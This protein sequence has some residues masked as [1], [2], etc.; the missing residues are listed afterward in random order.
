MPTLRYPIIPLPAPLVYGS[1][2]LAKDRSPRDLGGK[3]DWASNCSGPW[4]AT[5]FQATW[6]RHSIER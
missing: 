6:L 2:P 5:D 1:P 3:P 4:L